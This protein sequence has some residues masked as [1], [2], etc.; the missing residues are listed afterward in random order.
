MSKR[1][2]KE[3]VSC[4]ECGGSHVSVVRRDSPHVDDNGKTLV[5]FH[6]SDCESEW[7]EERWEP[8]KPS[9]SR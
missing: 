2:R 5:M 3:E 6:C 1:R 7:V 9:G 4:P 8:I